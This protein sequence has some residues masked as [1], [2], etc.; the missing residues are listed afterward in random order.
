MLKVALR[1]VATEEALPLLDTMVAFLN[2][3]IY[4]LPRCK[5]CSLVSGSAKIRNVR[6]VGHTGGLQMSRLGTFVHIS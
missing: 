1:A 5:G 2:T 6:V 3:W 4:S